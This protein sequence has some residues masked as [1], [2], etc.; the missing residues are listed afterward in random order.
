MNFLKQQFRFLMAISFAVL[1]FSSANACY[2]GCV[3]D[4]C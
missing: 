4:K 2:T 3:K 1:S